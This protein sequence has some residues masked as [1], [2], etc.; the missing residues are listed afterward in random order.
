MWTLGSHV[1]NRESVKSGSD[2][3]EDD[4]DILTENNVQKNYNSSQINT[5][6]VT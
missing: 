5:C 3:D 2:D 6:R 4:K 1:V